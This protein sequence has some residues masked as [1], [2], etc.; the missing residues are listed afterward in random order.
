MFSGL[1]TWAELHPCFSWVSNLQMDDHENQ[2]FSASKIYT[3]THTYSCYW[4]SGEHWLTQKSSNVQKSM[5]ERNIQRRYAFNFEGYRRVSRI[6]DSG[7]IMKQL[8][9]LSEKHPREM[10]KKDD[11]EGAVIR[12]KMS[13]LNTSIRGYNCRDY[14]CRTESKYYKTWPKKNKSHNCEVGWPTAD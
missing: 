9:A 14:I 11:R 3:Y 12:L 8:W 7:T 1:W 5:R 10:N 4:V 6:K 13:H 2:Q